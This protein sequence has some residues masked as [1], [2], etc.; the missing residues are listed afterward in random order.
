MTWTPCAGGQVCRWSRHTRSACSPEHRLSQPPDLSRRDVAIVALASVTLIRGNFHQIAVGVAAIDR[1]D[2]T[3][4][5]SAFDR[6]LDDRHAELVQVA[7]HLVWRHG[8]DETQ[9]PRAGFMRGPGGPRVD[10]VI[11][12]PEVDLLATKFQSGPV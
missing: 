8:G 10:V 12:R 1:L 3:Q 7:D 4:G 2:W 6:S 9:I 11:V 5:A